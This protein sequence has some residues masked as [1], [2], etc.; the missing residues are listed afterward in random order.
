MQKLTGPPPWPWVL[1][2]PPTAHSRPQETT[3]PWTSDLSF[4][5]QGH[6]S[7][8]ASERPLWGRL[9]WTR[10]PGNV[11]Q[12]SH[13]RGAQEQAHVFSGKSTRLA[14]RQLPKE[15]VWKVGHLGGFMHPWGQNPS[16]ALHVPI[17]AWL[18]L[19]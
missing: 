16:R 10:C 9:C 8:E 6:F 2:Q 18:A 19:W 15:R 11:L 14:F 12:S 3:H 1:S 5:I 7:P 13:Q 4:L 17:Q